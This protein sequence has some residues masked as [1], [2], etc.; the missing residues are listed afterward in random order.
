ML[1]VSLI[2]VE[3][4]EKNYFE[5]NKFLTS[6]KEC[7]KGSIKYTEE[8]YSLHI[9]RNTN[10]RKYKWIIT[11]ER[12]SEYK[13]IAVSF[14]LKHF[15]N[16]RGIKRYNRNK[17]SDCID[18]II[19]LRLLTECFNLC[20]KENSGFS[21]C[22]YALDDDNTQKREDLNRRMSVYCNFLNRKSINN[23]Y[24][25]KQK[26]NIYNNLFVG[27]NSNFCNEND[28]DNFLKIY[29]P[30]MLEEAN[31]LYDEQNSLKL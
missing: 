13:V 21:F 19:V 17:G 31:G 18:P 26:G 4:L 27:Y 30:I 10:K 15:S 23:K 1:R 24:Q 3:M 20:V 25:F 2:L 16:S 8:L 28:I 5:V 6:K 14:Y 29:T 22:F 9:K 11:L 7:F 12:Y